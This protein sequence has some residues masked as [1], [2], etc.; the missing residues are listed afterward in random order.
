[1]QLPLTPTGMEVRYEALGIRMGT[2]EDRDILDGGDEAL[3]ER[4]RKQLAGKRSAREARE[5][6]QE[7]TNCSAGSGPA[8]ASTRPRSTG[9]GAGTIFY[10]RGPVG[11]GRN[12]GWTPPTRPTE[13]VVLEEA[14]VGQVVECKE[15]NV[16]VIE[17]PVTK[18][19]PRWAAMCK[20][21]EICITDRRSRLW[22]HLADVADLAEATGEDGDAASE[23]GQARLT[24]ADVIFMDLETTGL[25]SSPLFLIG[26]ML[27]RDGQLV[28]KQIFARDYSEER[29]ALAM[30]LSD[31]ADKKLLVSFNG[32]S[33]DVPY[34]RVR[35]AA[36]GLACNLDPPHL[37]LL[38]TGRRIWKGRFADCKL[39][40]LEQHV[41]G[42]TR[43]GDI[44]GSQIPQAYH[45]YV[46]TDNAWQMVA[47]LEHNMLD[48]VTLADLMTRLPDRS[49]V[50]H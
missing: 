31:A 24:P 27:W 18:I 45:D 5:A 9:S 32:K 44:P 17:S 43:T 14:V 29:A 38:H 10:G 20:A 40:T 36:V 26:T 4:L 30:F 34:V 28:V 1:M 13:M 48:L 49:S 37:D 21:F 41:C 16:F 33:F 6:G 25:G 50:G 47:C 46:R 2:S 12:A 35:A 3:R 7:V 15:G 22:S 11:G 19:D 39:Q 42:R 8:D 23:A